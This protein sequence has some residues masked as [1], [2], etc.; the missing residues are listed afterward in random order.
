MPSTIITGTNSGIGHTFALQV[1][2]GYKVLATGLTIGDKLKG[3]ACDTTQLDVSSHASIQAFK[4]G[5][6]YHPLD[7]LLSIAD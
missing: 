3:L 7:L 5:F 4:H 6:K 2:E 1:K